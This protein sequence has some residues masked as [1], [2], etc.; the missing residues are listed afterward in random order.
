[1]YRKGAILSEVMSWYL[2]NGEM[3]WYPLQGSQ[4]CVFHDTA[5]IDI[6]N[7]AGNVSL[8]IC[9][10]GHEWATQL[11]KAKVSGWIVLVGAGGVILY[12]WRKSLKNSSD[13]PPR[14]PRLSA[15]SFMKWLL[16]EELLEDGYDDTSNVHGY[17]FGPS[18]SESNGQYSSNDADE[19]NDSDDLS[20]NSLSAK[21]S[22]CKF[23]KK[24]LF[25]LSFKGNTA[26]F[27]NLVTCTNTENSTWI[28]NPCPKCEKGTCRLK[29]HQLPKNP[30]NSSSC[31]SDSPIL[32]L[33]SSTPDILS[34]EED[35][36]LQRTVASNKLTYRYYR[37]GVDLRMQG[38][39]SDQVE[40]EDCI[41][42]SSLKT[43]RG[44][45]LKLYG[46]TPQ[47]ASMGRDRW[48]L[49]PSS[50]SRVE[51][52][53]SS[54]ACGDPACSDPQCYGLV[55]L[56]RDLS[57]DSLA[58]Q[59]YAMNTSMMDLVLNA[60]EARRLIREISFDSQASD[61]DID[62]SFA[63][64]CGGAASEG[65]NQLYNGLNQLIDNC[66]FVSNIP[67]DNKL[68]YSRSSES[69]LSELSELF[70]P[71]EEIRENSVPDFQKLQ[72]SAFNSKELWKLTGFTDSSDPSDAENASLEWDS[73]MHGWNTRP[74]YNVIAH[75]ELNT[76]DSIEDRSSFEGSTLDLLEWDNECLNPSY[77]NEIFD[78]SAQSYS[79]MLSEKGYD[80]SSETSR[81]TSRRPSTDMNMRYI[82]RLPPSGRSSVERDL[83]ASRLSDFSTASDKVTIT[84]AL[85][86]ARPGY[87]T[88]SRSSSIT[89][90]CSGSLSPVV[91]DLPFKFPNSNNKDS[92][93]NVMNISACSEESGFLDYEGSMDSSISSSH[94]M[95]SSFF[96]SSINLS[97]VKEAKEPCSPYEGPT[98]FL[99]SPE[100]GFGSITTSE[101]VIKVSLPNTEVLRPEPKKASRGLFRKTEETLKS[102]GNKL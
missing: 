89:R 69:G 20:L 80:G 62:I 79:V 56:G 44:R 100:F 77:D 70:D 53:S 99:D 76:S 9:K 32:A 48:S 87:T 67:G 15:R 18:L 5:S 65:F 11:N 55:Q 26:R 43:K 94:S 85:P 88:R 41:T 54:P 58:D 29:K 23:L 16:D 12:L 39:G 22:P 31:Y 45:K 6:L 66:D 8:E 47:G 17:Y 14:S 82:P 102:E 90:S 61:L 38:D 72:K 10:F 74:I 71:S 98:G 24:P 86:Y 63:D 75:K 4:D 83:S 27:K 21:S 13:T 7:F 81:N 91:R 3:S 78:G 101:T 50:R 36:I 52:C 49:S 34:G 96:T 28:T 92:S 30:S 59:S 25:D 19:E 37:P 57:I 42:P 1:M 46:K 60:K 51:S 73:P 68:K 2:T 40:D 64:T 95:N 84:S 35:Q 33:K 93:A 97:P